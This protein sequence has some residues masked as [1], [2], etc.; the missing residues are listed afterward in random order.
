MVGYAV[1]SSGGAIAAGQAQPFY[2]GARVN[3]PCLES[4]ASPGQTAEFGLIAVGGV[5]LVLQATLRS[6]GN[7]GI[8]IGDGYTVGHGPNPLGLS[9]TLCSNG[10]T[11]SIVNLYVLMNAGCAAAP[12][13]GITRSVP[14]DP[15]AMRGTGSRDSH[16]REQLGGPGRYV[17]KTVYN[18]T[19]LIED[20]P[21]LSES[22]VTGCDVLQFAPKVEFA[23]AQ[24]T[25]DGTTQADE[26]TG[27]TFALKVP[28][29][30]ETGV[31]ATPC[32][33]G[34]DGDVARRDDG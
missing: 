22:F 32:V 6:D 12:Q 14:N 19:S 27:A 4:R 7:Y 24:A 34:R 23:P 3:K 30:N 25:E 8:T 13:P 21:S 17:S 9:L 16:A 33:E 20:G 2:Y 29:T 31:N 11:G 15:D 18:G 10:V 28:Q 1:P 26:P 5:P